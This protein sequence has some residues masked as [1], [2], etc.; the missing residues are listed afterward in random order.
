MGRIP[1]KYSVLGSQKLPRGLPRRRGDGGVIVD[2][3]GLDALVVRVP[4]GGRRLKGGG[5]RFDTFHNA[6]LG[7]QGQA[8]HLRFVVIKVGSWKLQLSNFAAG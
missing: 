6:I 8:T 3:V 1:Q 4:V 5:S 2:V 7:G